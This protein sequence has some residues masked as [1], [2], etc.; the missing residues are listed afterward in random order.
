M[1]AMSSE[2]GAETH[3][4]AEYQGILAAKSRHRG[5]RLAVV[6]LKVIAVIYFVAGVLVA[7]S[8]HEKRTREHERRVIE[9]AHN[10]Y[11]DVPEKPSFA[12]LAVPLFRDAL[13]AF[14]IFVA[15]DVIKLQLA[16]RDEL[17]RLSAKI[18]A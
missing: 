1:V 2:E 16:T 11:V 8:E 3:D 7:A 18:G 15:G 9:A 14:F 5:L 6:V 12:V 13:I 17:E 10:A 4:V